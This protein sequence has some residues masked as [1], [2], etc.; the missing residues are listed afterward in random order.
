M[1]V[2]PSHPISILVGS[3]CKLDFDRHDTA[4]DGRPADVAGEVAL[5][6]AD[7]DDIGVVAASVTTLLVEAVYEFELM[8]HPMP[9]PMASAAT[10]PS[11]SPNRT[12]VLRRNVT[13]AV[14]RLAL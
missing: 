13:I 5:E 1:I 7:G 10:M 9:K 14:F 2:F 8:A 3:I 12:T 11:A 4:V 6:I